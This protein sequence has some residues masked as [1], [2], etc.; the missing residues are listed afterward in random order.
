MWVKWK[1]KKSGILDA[2]AG[3]CEEGVS[4]SIR[5]QHVAAHLYFNDGGS[6]LFYLRNLVTGSMSHGTEQFV[7][8]LRKL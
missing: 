3:R 7:A 2:L 6:L 8:G 1:V 5:L 4:I